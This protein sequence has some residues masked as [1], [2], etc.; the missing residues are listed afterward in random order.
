MRAFNWVL[1]FVMLL[2][3]TGFTFYVSEKI[4]RVSVNESEL[5]P[6]EEMLERGH[7]LAQAA[8]CNNC[9]AVDGDETDLS[10]GL[11]ITTPFGEFYSTNLTP[12]RE[13]GIGTWQLEDFV[14]ALRHGI[15]PHGEHYY[16]VFPYTSYTNMTTADIASLYYY[17]RTLKPVKKYTRP[18]STIWFAWR[19]GIR[20]W[21]R[22]GFETGP[23]V[24]DP[25]KPPS[26]NA[27]N[28]VAN[29][30]LHCA[31]CHTSRDRIGRLN[32]AVKFSGNP[33]GINNE[34]VPNITSARHGGIGRW[35]EAELRTFLSVGSKPDGTLAEGLMSHVIKGASSKLER[36]DLESLTVYIRSISAV[37][38]E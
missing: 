13:T 23:L 34:P 5:P 14:R 25:L 28:Y 19:G 6:E 31:E 37:E 3:L 2:A 10:G 24:A 26:W 38:E 35:T 32:R 15:S 18:H 22:F 11:K 12:D 20:L 1:L 27:G 33:R 21:K 29:A 8:G 36:R 17:L 16:P 9:H 30:V 7:Y 4:P